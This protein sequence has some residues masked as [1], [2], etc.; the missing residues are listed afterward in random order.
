MKPQSAISASPNAPR[1]LVATRFGIGI[2]D[3]AWFEHRLALMSAITAPSLLA[4]SDQEFV[5]GIFVGANLPE[6]ARRG[7]E[8]IVAPFE[9]RAFIDFKGHT[10]DNL[11]ALAVE[12]GLEHPSGH[13]LTGRI[14]DDDAWSTHTVEEVRA[15]TGD[16]LSRQSSRPGFGLTFA[17]GLVWVMYDM[18]D[19]DRLQSVGDSTERPASIRAYSCP[20]ISI[21]EF[22]CSPLSIGMT[23]IKGSHAKVPEELESEGFEIHVVDNES[24]MWLYCRHKQ[25][26]SGIERATPEDELELSAESLA[27]LFGID[28]ERTDAYI[29]R[30]AEYGY[31]TKKR[32][33]DRRGELHNEFTDAEGRAADLASHEL[34]LADLAGKASRRR[35][36]WARLGHDLIAQPNQDPGTV[37][38]SHVIQTPFS[39][40][41]RQERQELSREQLEARLRQLDSHCLSSLAA[42]TSKAFLWHVYCDEDTD[43]AMLRALQERAARFPQMRIAITGPNSR[44]PATHALDDTRLV[45]AVLLTTHLDCDGAIASDRIAAIHGHVDEFG[46]GGEESFLLEIPRLGAANGRLA[47]GQSP[48]SALRTLFERL[49]AVPVT[50]LS[51]AEGIDAAAAD[52]QPHG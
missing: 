36:E 4:Q 29:R 31:S 46:R 47:D 33:F 10:P 3:P 50:M 44:T 6:R 34:E 17:N 20:W 28:G 40:Q 24:P 2:S 8:D 39:N 22:V 25:T 43:E 45:D 48:P 49:T 23:P 51:A 37:A 15:F 26:D 41:P 52:P 9:G 35:D 5:W 16:W 38:F 13:V 7:L 19:I 21:S 27:D 18:L 30:S 11:L 1:L 32:L 12:R 42:Q 14:D